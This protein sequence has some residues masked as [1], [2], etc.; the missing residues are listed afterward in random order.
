VAARG[1]RGALSDGIL[2]QLRHSGEP[3][4]V[5]ERSHLYALL[6]A[7]A[8]AQRRRRLRQGGDKGVIHAVLHQEARG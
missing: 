8:D 6:K 7:V 1:G 3:P 5:G 4:R 2:H